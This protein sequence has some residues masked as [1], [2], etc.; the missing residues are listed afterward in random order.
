[1]QSSNQTP[2]ITSFVIRF[3]HTPSAEPQTQSAYRGL[4]RHI[5]TN[6]EINFTHWA[7]AVAFIQNFV[8]L[9]DVGD[10]ELDDVD[11]PSAAEP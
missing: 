7:D 11:G 3:V 9:E 8:L 4:I 2:D 1:M 10:D 6:Q 5:Q